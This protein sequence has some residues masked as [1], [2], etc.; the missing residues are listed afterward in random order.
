MARVSIPQNLNLLL[1]PL[2]NRNR[3]H[4]VLP[5][6]R[7]PKNLMLETEGSRGVDT[8]PSVT[9]QDRAV[10]PMRASC[11]DTSLNEAGE[12]KRHSAICVS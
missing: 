5:M 2:C 4:C 1:P 6:D 11:D 7:A 8:D 12:A 3:Q 10:T 9:R